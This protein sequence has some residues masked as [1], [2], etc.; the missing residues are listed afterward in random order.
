MLLHICK[1]AKSYSDIR[2]VEGQLYPTFQAACQALGL[3]GDDR[4][5]SSAMIDAAHWALAYLL[6]ELFVTILLFC[7]VSSPLAFFEEHISIMGEDA[8]YHATCGR[9]LLPASSLMRHVR[10]YVIS[11]IDKLLTNAGYSL[12][13]FNLPQPTLGSTPIYGNRLLMDEQEYDLNKISVEAIEQLSR[14]NMNQR[15]VYDAIMHSVN[16]KIGHTFFV[17]GYGGTG[18]TFL[19]N[20]LLNN[21][22]AQ[23]KI[24]LEVLLE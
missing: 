18:K 15:H 2:T 17:Y 22:R 4:E 3:L 6:R 13:H 21:I 23:G 12:E 1:G 7:D 20:T 10:S 24:A 19:W 14:L 16:N 9:S 8:T 11:E 5:W